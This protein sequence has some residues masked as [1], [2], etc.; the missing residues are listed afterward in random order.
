MGEN[1]KRQNPENRKERN[2]NSESLE[3]QTSGR[4]NITKD[5]EESAHL[6]EK[7]SGLGR[8]HKNSGIATKDGTTGSDYDGQVTDR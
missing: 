7:S 1:T 4:Q 3:Q 6:D 2:E 5:H 8:R